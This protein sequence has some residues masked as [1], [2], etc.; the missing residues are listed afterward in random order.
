M[1]LFLTMVCEEIHAPEAVCQELV[2]LLQVPDYYQLFHPVDLSKCRRVNNFQRLTRMKEIQALV[3][4]FNNSQL[5]ARMGHNMGTGDISFTISLPKHPK[6][7]ILWSMLALLP[8]QQSCEKYVSEKL[9][10]SQNLA[11]ESMK[12]FKQQSSLTLCVREFDLSRGSLR[13]IFASDDDL[14]DPTLEKEEFV[15]SPYYA[16][17]TGYQPTERMFSESAMSAQKSHLVDQ[18]VNSFWH[19]MAEKRN[20]MAVESLR[21]PLT[22]ALYE[23]FAH[24]IHGQSSTFLPTNVTPFCFYLFGTAG[25]GK[26]AFVQAFRAALQDVLQQYVEPTKVVQVVKLPLNAFTAGNLGGGLRVRGISDMSIERI[27]E[28]TLCK[29][30]VVIFHLEENPEDPELQEK[31]YQQTKAMLDKLVSRYPHYRSNILSVITSNYPAVPAIMKEATSLTMTALS[32]AQQYEWVCGMLR[33]ALRQRMGDRVQLDMHIEAS[34][35]VVTDLRPLEQWWRSLTFAVGSF[36]LDHQAEGSVQVSLTG[37]VGRYLLQ[38]TNQPEWGSL[39]LHSHNSFFYFNAQ[40]EESL[41]L[42]ETHALPVGSTQV[43]TS[44]VRMTES[45]FLQPAVVILRGEQAFRDRWCAAIQEYVQDRF[46]HRLRS[47]DVEL[48][49]RRIRSR[50]LVN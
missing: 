1:G 14:C 12:L 41:L 40:V 2:K 37:A 24:G 31:L 29:G 42:T 20:Y 34:I 49:P 22:Q 48:Y 10:R 33:K 4:L 38:V 44:I 6:S 8:W 25:I 28:Q 32:A 46:D 36:L 35:P 18:M 9:G 3:T 39:E 16:Q 17:I 11:N 30:G 27:I 45:E 47:E 13:I 26:S 19:D 43:F 7:L 23:F 5:P 15:Y 21:T 50:C